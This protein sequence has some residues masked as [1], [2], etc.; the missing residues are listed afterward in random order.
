VA[1]D[2]GGCVV[3]VAE[4]TEDWVGD[5]SEETEDWVVEV[6]AVEACDVLVLAEEDVITS[7]AWVADGTG[8]VDTVIVV[9]ILLEGLDCLETVSKGQ[10]T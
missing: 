5:V 4:E 6:V 10:S 8:A 7:I 2:E 3:E 9:L 1:V